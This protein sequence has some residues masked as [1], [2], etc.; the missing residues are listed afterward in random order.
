LGNLLSEDEETKIDPKLMQTNKALAEGDLDLY[1][2]I[3]DGDNLD[4]KAMIGSHLPK[5]G[6]NI[7]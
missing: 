7:L 1:W 2:K 6:E 4:Y 5:M 3:R